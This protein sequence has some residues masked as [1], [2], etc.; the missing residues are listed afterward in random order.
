MTPTGSIAASIAF[1]SCDE[2]PITNATNAS[3]TGLLTNTLYY[4]RVAAT[5]AAGRS[6]YGYASARTWSV[7]EAWHRAYFSGSDLVNLSISGPTADPDHDGL[8][9]EQEYWAGTIPTNAASC[10]V[11][12]ALT[13][14]PVV[15]GEYV[16]RWQSVA[17]KHYAVQSTTNLLIG[18][19][20]LRTNIL[21]TPVV[22]V[23]TD[24]V[25][26]VGCRFYRVKLE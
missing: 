13:N 14:N 7:Y 26:G 15:P 5:N 12:Y 25:S 10:L 21:A 19:S 6:A 2:R 11:L 17:G 1:A 22:N 8:N 23:H 9:N 16:V 20:D 4:Y 18:F 3:N 24:N